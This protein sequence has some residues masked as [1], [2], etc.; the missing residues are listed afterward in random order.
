[1]KRQLRLLYRGFLSQFMKLIFAVPSHKVRIG[2]M[3]LLGM[4]IPWSVGLYT[5]CEIRNPKGIQIGKGTVI[6]NRCLLDGRRGIV[7]GEKVNISP[8]V[9]V[10]T[11]HH[12]YNDPGFVQIGDSVKID[13][14]AWIC[15]RAIILPGVHIG[16]GAVVASGAVVTKDVEPYT[17]VGGIP[18][19]KIAERNK[20][21]NYN[22]VVRPLG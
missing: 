12:D 9:F 5:G 14:Y 10:W 7:I 15:S 1:M 6:G 16:E 4:K 13:N 22:L 3:K 11:L 17:V 2:T 8:E 18:A 21:L 19:K 20:N